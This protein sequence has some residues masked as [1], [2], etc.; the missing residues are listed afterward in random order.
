MT[1]N[2]KTMPSEILIWIYENNERV[3]LEECPYNSG[4]EQAIEEG[5][6]QLFD[7]SSPWIGGDVY[8][9]TEMTCD[10]TE[11]GAG[12]Y[13]CL[14]SDTG[15]PT[16]F[17][18]EW[19][20]KNLNKRFILNNPDEM[21]PILTLYYHPWKYRV[22]VLFTDKKAPAP[23]FNLPPSDED[24][25]KMSKESQRIQDAINSMSKM[26]IL[27]EGNQNSVRDI[28]K[29]LVSEIKAL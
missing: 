21:E 24:K 23:L 2:T 13:R 19:I 9:E 12:V 22:E 14:D 25:K 8:Y 6:R 11:E 27:T 5:I 17:P 4:D 15:K 16:P 28:L 18:E 10:V 7:S 26:G 1:D 20:E 3:N 29:K